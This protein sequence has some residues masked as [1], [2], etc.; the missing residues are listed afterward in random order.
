M[1]TGAV[2]TAGT[3]ILAGVGETT[4]SAENAA[5]ADGVV[6]S[7]YGPVRGADETQQSVMGAT[8]TPVT[9]TGSVSVVVPETAALNDA[10]TG[11]TS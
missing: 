1:Q 5:S 3:S 9:E 2:Q 7:S 11:T 4:A 10:R 6:I 8:S